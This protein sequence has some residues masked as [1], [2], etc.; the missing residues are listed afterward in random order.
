M[1]DTARPNDIRLRNTALTCLGVAAGML[2]LA[3]AAVP[4]YDLFCRVTGFGGTPILATAPSGKVLERTVA[5]RFDTNVAPGLPWRFSAETPAVRIKVGETQT[6]TYIIH[7]PSDA[8]V[9]A[10]ATYNVQP[11]LAGSY[12]M[13]LECFC[14][15]EMTLK[16]GETMETAVVFFI[17]PAIVDDPDI[18]SLDAITLSYTYFPPK[19]VNP[20]QPAAR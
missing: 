19:G 2:G 8:S 15:T 13:K 17:D 20:A 3:Y 14:F 4:L 11:E 10:M 18:G 9:S 5:V 6:V 1:S 7:N 12:F 16:P